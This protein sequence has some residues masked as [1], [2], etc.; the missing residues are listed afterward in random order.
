VTSVF[1]A[2]SSFT[3]ADGITPRGLHCMNW[4]IRLGGKIAV[5]RFVARRHRGPGGV[6]P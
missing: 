6:T 4:R 2:S 5:F 3:I 1:S